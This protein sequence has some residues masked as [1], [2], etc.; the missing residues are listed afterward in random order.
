MK[1]IEYN[2]KEEWS[3]SDDKGLLIDENGRENRRIIE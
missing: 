3:Q 2:V 1:R